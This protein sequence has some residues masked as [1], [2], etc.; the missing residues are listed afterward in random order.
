[1][2]NKKGLTLVEILIVLTILSVLIIAAVSGMDPI[3]TMAKARDTQRKKDLNRIK[4]AFEDYFNDRNC[5]PS[6]GLVDML[7][8]VSRCKS[9]VFSPWLGNWPCNPGDTPYSIVIGD[10]E[11]CPKWYKVMTF[12][13]NKSDPQISDQG[14]IGDGVGIPL[15]YGVAS[16]NISLT[17]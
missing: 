10:D 1:M 6:Q 12:L 9:D 4:I 7:T 8:D 2:K 13:E 17:Q 15:N 14:G 16:E 3:G 11:N 5:Y